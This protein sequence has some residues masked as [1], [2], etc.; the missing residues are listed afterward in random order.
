T[1]RF[2]D[3]RKVSVCLC[4]A[5]WADIVHALAEVQFALCVV[6]TTCCCGGRTGAHALRAPHRA[7]ITSIP[8]RR[9]STITDVA[10]ANPRVEFTSGIYIGALVATSV[11]DARRRRR[12]L[13]ASI[14]RSG[15][16]GVAHLSA[17]SWSLGR[18]HRA[19]GS[20]DRNDRTVIVAARSSRHCQGGQAQG[21]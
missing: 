11:N 2:A 4:D 12:I 16:R 9:R 5:R 1:R 20:V 3:T 14:R 15:R 17:V 13:V 18:L 10:R 21:N 7:T 6:L 19:V 8:L